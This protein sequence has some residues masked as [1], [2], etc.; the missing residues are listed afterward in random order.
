MLKVRP[1]MLLLALATTWFAAGIA[2]IYTGVTAASGPWTVG[3]ALGAALVYVVFLVMFL[4][5]A[6]KHIRRIQAYTEELVNLFWFLDAP[7]YIILAV[8]VGIGASVRI[9][10]LVPGAAIALFYSGLGLALIT[11]AVR[12]TVTYIAICDELIANRLTQKSE[13]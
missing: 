5:I 10:G 9:S 8:M 11:A 1:K 12:Y 2:V 7:S 4:M 13:E 3:M 6:R